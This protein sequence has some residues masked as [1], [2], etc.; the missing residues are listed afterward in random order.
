MKQEFGFD[1]VDNENPMEIFNLKGDVIQ[2]GFLGK[3]ALQV[4][5]VRGILSLMDEFSSGLYLCN[6]NV[7]LVLGRNNLH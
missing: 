2:S 4:A 6:I 3:I 5:L 1:L 7:Y